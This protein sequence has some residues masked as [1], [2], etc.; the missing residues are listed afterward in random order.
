MTEGG[1]DER[2]ILPRQFEYLFSEIAKIKTLHKLARE[3]RGEGRRTPSQHRLKS[4][5]FSNIGDDVEELFFEVVCSYSEIYNEQIF[6][7]LDVSQ[8]KKLQIR[9]DAQR[10]IILEG[11]TQEAVSSPADVDRLI[12][13]GQANRSVAATNMNRESSRSHAIFTAY[14]RMRTVDKDNRETLR[15]SKLNVVD[16]A[17]SERVKDTHA[18]G[19][20]LKEACKINVS[21]TFLGRVINF[22]A[23]AQSKSKRHNAYIN[24]RES[25]L[26]HLLKDSLGGNS[27]TVIICTLNPNQMAIRETLSTLKFAE[28]AKKIK[29]KAR[30]NEQGNEGLFKKKYEELLKEIERLK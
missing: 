25:K 12:K 21:L 6:D 10:G 4:S 16:L 28:R 2:G 30:V 27:K 18:E 3:K 15:H 20:R 23:E 13:R 9:E 7:L 5:G 11:E 26:T 24:Y 17:G 1:P 22:L 29:N 19:M 14:I 8:N